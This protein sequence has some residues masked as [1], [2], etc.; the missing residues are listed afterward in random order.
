MHPTL[1][2][3]DRLASHL[4]ADAQVQAILGL[5]SAGTETDRFDEHSDIDFFV[6][7][8]DQPAKQRYL[9]DIGWLDGF[10]GNLTYSFVNDRNGRKALFDDGLFIEYAIFTPSELAEI[11]FSGARVIW[12]KPAFALPQQQNKRPATAL[13]TVDFHL[14]EAL[15]NLFVGLHRERRGEHLT[16]MRFIQ[17]YAVDRVLSLIRLSPTTRWPMPDPFETTRRIEQSGT[18]HPP[19]LAQMA[20][21]YDRNATAAKATLDWLTSHYEA[22]PSIV[23]SIQELL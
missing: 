4:S 17:V 3:L 8:D 11:R 5:G 7:L 19:P 14:N 13:E 23:E 2:R 20:A 18:A 15:T 12:S 9:S 22:D 1:K 6:I 10:G 16:A 21:G